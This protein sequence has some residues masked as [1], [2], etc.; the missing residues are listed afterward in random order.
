MTVTLHLIFY[1]ALLA[2]IMISRTYQCHLEFHTELLHLSGCLNTSIEIETTYCQ[3]YCSSQ[4]YLIYDWQSES[5]PYRHQH[6]ITCCSPKMTVSREMKVLCDDRQPRIIKYP[7]V[8]R[9]QCRA[10]TEICIS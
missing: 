5:R 1:A 3:G 2:A 8:I 4:D 9:C 10:C 6:N 7:L